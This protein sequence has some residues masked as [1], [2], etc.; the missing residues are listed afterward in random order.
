M[1][2]NA[3]AKQ[4]LNWQ[5]DCLRR[6]EMQKKDQLLVA[7]LTLQQYLCMTLKEKL[8]VEEQQDP[9]VIAIEEQIKWAKN[10]LDQE[11]PQ[12]NISV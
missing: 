7:L 5:A 11:E 4:D 10:A 8:T 12:W 2:I 9:K 6:D 3:I 1:G